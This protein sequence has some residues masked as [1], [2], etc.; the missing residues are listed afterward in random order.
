MGNYLLARLEGE[1]LSVERLKSVIQELDEVRLYFENEVQYDE[2][3][4]EVHPK[5]FSTLF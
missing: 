5:K 2:D 4:D 3:E 1:W